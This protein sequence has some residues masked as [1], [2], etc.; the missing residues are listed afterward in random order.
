MLKARAESSVQ[1]SLNSPPASSPDS[2]A[3]ASLMNSTTCRHGS[4]RREVGTVKGLQAVG[5]EGMEG[6]KKNKNKERFIAGRRPACITPR[7]RGGSTHG[8]AAEGWF[9]AAAATHEALADVFSGELAEAVLENAGPAHAEAEAGEARL[10]APGLV[11]GHQLLEEPQPFVE[12]KREG[13]GAQQPRAPGRF[14]LD[15][16]ARRHRPTRATAQGTRA[17]AAPPKATTAATTTVAAT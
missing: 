13:H 9:S 3:P 1:N 17:T 12:G 14:P 6:M 5:G 10:L 2:A 8:V 4:V 16:P 15:L 7:G 11:R